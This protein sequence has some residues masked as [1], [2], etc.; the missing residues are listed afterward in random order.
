[1]A[2][3]AALEAQLAVV[4]GFENPKVALEQYPT[5]PDLAAHLV[6]LADL[7]GDVDGKTVVDLGTG[8]GMLALG[9]ALRSPARVVGV[10]LDADALE[11]AVDNARRVGASAPVHWVRGDATRLPLCLSERE[12]VTVLMNPPFGAQNENAHAD[13]AFLET[14]ASLADVSYSVHNEG[15][16]EFI[17]AFADDA[18]A[19]VTDAFRAT[20]DLD[21]QFDFHEAERRELDAEVFRIEW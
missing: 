17:E 13:R 7:R 2:T 10:E 4:A 19:D 16:K 11:T 12:P 14:I 8:T 15:S 3:K 5:P 1:M 21:H 18:G 6:H 9:A 20:F